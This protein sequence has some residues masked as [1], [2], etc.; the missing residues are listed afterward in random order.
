MLNFSDYDSLKTV[1]NKWVETALTEA[2]KKDRKWTKSI[3]V[4]D[5]QFIENTRERLGDKAKG[6]GKMESETG[7]ELR[8]DQLVYGEFDL[9]NKYYWDNNIR[10]EGPF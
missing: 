6:R 4:G 1:H 8:E 7:F 10:L 2:N 3:A 9:D 5:E